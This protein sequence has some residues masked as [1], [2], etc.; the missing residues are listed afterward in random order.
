MFKLFRKENCI[1]AEVTSF[2]QQ[3]KYRRKKAD[4]FIRM[5]SEA[6]PYVAEEVWGMRDKEL[7]ID[8]NIVFQLEDKRFY[9]IEERNDTIEEVEMLKGQLYWRS[10]Q[11]IMNY[12]KDMIEDI[13]ERD[14]GRNR[15]VAEMA[16]L[17]QQ[18]KNSPIIT[19]INEKVF[20]V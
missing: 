6:I 3:E 8:D 17:T 1:Q 18:M 7:V 12:A 13:Q 14:T 11:V 10:V 19:D 20:R 2:I 5:L 15:L 4:E 9:L 16:N